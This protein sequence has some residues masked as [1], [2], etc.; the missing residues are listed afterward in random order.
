[1]DPVPSVLASYRAERMIFGQQVDAL[2]FEYGLCE[3][4]SAMCF[5][6]QPF[7]LAGLHSLTL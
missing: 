5:S 4:F 6:V 7:R 3:A 2:T 1:M